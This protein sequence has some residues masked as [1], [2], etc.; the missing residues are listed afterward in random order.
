MNMSG[1][2]PTMPSIRVLHP[3]ISAAWFLLGGVFLIVAACGGL[4][5]GADP[6]V[7]DWVVVSDSSDL[8]D[9]PYVTIQKEGDHF[10]WIVDDRKFIA[11]RDG[12]F[13][14]VDTTFAAV[15]VLRDGNELVARV[16]GEETRFRRR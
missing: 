9:D 10:L 6:F 16:L 5:S 14:N 11:S 13:L 3:S 2:I 7:G 4:G 1:M 8:F 12:D 15:K